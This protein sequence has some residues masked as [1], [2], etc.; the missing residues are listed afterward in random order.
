MRYAWRRLA[1]EEQGYLKRTI[2]NEEIFPR[3]QQ[4]G[5]FRLTPRM[6]DSTNE[7]MY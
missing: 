4:P 7:L 5:G 6:R 1:E 3:S 2:Y